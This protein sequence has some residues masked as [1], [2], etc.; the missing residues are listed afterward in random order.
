M[1]GSIKIHIYNHIKDLTDERGFPKA[2][3]DEVKYSMWNEFIAHIE[4]GESA[5]YCPAAFEGNE[6]IEQSIF[7]LEFYNDMPEQRITF[8]KAVELCNFLTLLPA[9]YYHHT[10][11]TDTQEKFSIGFIFD[12]PIKNILLRN[13]IADTLLDLFPQADK[14]CGKINRIFFGTKN[15]VIST[16]GKICLDSFISSNIRWSNTIFI[17]GGQ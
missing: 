16:R 1:K 4:K 6:W 15:K 2:F 8:T 7:V 3:A 12:K 11:S 9:F 5:L 17:G 13:R 10:D 14:T